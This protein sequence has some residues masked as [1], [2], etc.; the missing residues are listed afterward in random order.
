MLSLVSL[1]ADIA[2]EMLYPIV[3]VYLKNIGFSVVLI[4]LLEG[5]A[6]T[7]SGLMKGVFGQWSDRLGRRVP[8][9]RWGY[10]ISACSKPMLVLFSASWWIFFARTLDRFAKGMRTTPR[11]ALLSLEATPQ[12]KAQVFGFHR[13]LDTVG[14]VL[15]PLLAL[16][17]IHE[18]PNALA[19]MFYYSFIP[20]MLAV[21][22]TMLIR[23]H[24]QDRPQQ[25]ISQRSG[26][27]S[28][29][30]YWRRA[31]K[32]FRLI[33]IPMLVYMFFNSSDMFLLLQVRE[34]SGNDTAP[35][36]GYVVY[37]IVFAASSYIL[38]RVADRFGMKRVILFGLLCFSAAYAAI[39]KAR[40]TELI[41]LVFCIYGLSE[42]A[43]E[44]NIKAWLS[45]LV[46]RTEVGTALGL[47]AS[48]QSIAVFCASTIAGLLWFNFGA[49]AT[50]LSSSVAAFIAFLWLLGATNDAEHEL[51]QVELA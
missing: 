27:F 44:S 49:A 16:W 28:Y 14:A 20:G 24:A 15:G 46:P 19:M 30:G 50:F 47:F 5:L 8:F 25:V 42:S 4:G 31:P 26:L 29:F 48:L 2:S 13:S 3:P 10:F 45:N 39:T 1:F 38:G 51:N 18:H 33:A 35:I 40:S 36:L 41:F 23:E 12:T 17:Y 6:V 37:N 22:V 9:I 34:L 43:I 32:R 11:D 21:L 7:T